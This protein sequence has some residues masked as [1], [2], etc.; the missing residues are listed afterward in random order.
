MDALIVLR[1]LQL[2]AWVLESRDLPAFRERWP[3]GPATSSTARRAR[4]PRYV[5]P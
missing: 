5:Q 4:G 3:T 1:G 2:I